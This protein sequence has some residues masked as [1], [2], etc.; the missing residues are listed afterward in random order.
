MKK[1]NFIFLILAIISFGSHQFASA[2]N[3][4][5][6]T[7]YTIEEGIYD[8]GDSGICS[9]YIILTSNGFDLITES[10]NNLE[11]RCEHGGNLTTYHKIDS[12]LFQISF[13]KK[14]S[15]K[16]IFDCT[17]TKDNPRPC[18]DLYYKE[19]GELIIQ[20]GDEFISYK[21]IK[22]VSNNS[23]LLEPHKVQVLRLGKVLMSFPVDE[24]DK[25]HLFVKRP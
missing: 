2:E 12:N 8:T 7:N 14:A 24:N 13:R 3:S 10:R 11:S 18:N 16:D 20:V 1:L 15:I 4:E 21:N 9:Y 6:S 23:I 19:N 5:L 17:G 22:V 25:P